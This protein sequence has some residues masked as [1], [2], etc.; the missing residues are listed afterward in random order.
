MQPSDEADRLKR[1]AEHCRS[2]ALR[3]TDEVVLA[4]LMRLY[5]RYDELAH[6]L[7]RAES[8]TSAAAG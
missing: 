2:L 6:Q 7:E 8:A 4:Q 3:A 5:R 1:Q